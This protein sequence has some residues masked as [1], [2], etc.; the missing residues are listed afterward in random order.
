M[1][2]VVAEKRWW[3]PRIWRILHCLAEISDR[4]DC[5]GGWRIVLQE[6]ANMLPCDVCRAHFQEAIRNLRLPGPT[7]PL[8]PRSAV[9]HMLWFQHASTGGALPETDLTAEYGYGGDR[10][11]V[12]TEVQRLVGE[13]STAFREGHVLDRFRMPHLEPWARA[14]RQLANLLAVPEPPPQPMRRGR[15]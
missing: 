14:V 7:A 13:V 4:R 8:P 12:V 2:A 15:R 6:T 3:G 9:R 5:G 1:E 11:S 10:G